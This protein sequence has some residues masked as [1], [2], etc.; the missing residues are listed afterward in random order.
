MSKKLSNQEKLTN[1]WIVNTTYERK[2]EKLTYDDTVQV[3]P[4]SIVRVAIRRI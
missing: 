4:E 3:I 2:I 1:E